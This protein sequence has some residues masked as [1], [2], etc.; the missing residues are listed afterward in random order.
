[1]THDAVAKNPC[2]VHFFMRLPQRGRVK[3]R[4]AATVGHDLALHAYEAFVL[5]MLDMLERL[6][7]GVTTTI[8]ADDRPLRVEEWL[9]LHGKTRCKTISQVGNDLGERMY[10]AFEWGFAQGDQR[11]V[12]IGSDIPQLQTHDIQ[13]ALTC[14]EKA[15]SVIGPALDGGY[16]LIGF[17]RHALL[18][19]VFSNM[20]WG[21]GQVFEETMKRFSRAGMS[22]VVMQTYQDVDTWADLRAV[23]EELAPRSAAVVEQIHDSM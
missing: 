21:T 4:L 3:T 5:D 9:H 8:H 19:E 11:A 17:Q 14:L 6:G 12:L 22:P 7:S 15:P 10:K 20:T 18:P 1:M 16:Y 13:S 23:D 2:R